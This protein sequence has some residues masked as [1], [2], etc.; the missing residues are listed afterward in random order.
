MTEKSSLQLAF[1]A[2]VGAMSDQSTG[3]CRATYVV[4]FVSV[5]LPTNF[6]FTADTQRLKSC[7]SA[8]AT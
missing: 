4:E 7:Q 2:L 8:R 6:S 5:T 1:V 3:I